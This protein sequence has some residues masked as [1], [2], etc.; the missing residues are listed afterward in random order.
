MIGKTFVFAG[1]AQF[2]VE[3]PK[4]ETLTL[5]IQKAQK[6]FVARNGKVYPPA[7][8]LRTRHNNGEWTLIGRVDEQT[9][10]ITPTKNPNLPPPDD[11]I[12]GVAKWA[13]ETAVYEKPL[14]EGYR[15]AHV[16]KC[17][18]CGMTLTDAESIARGIGPECFK[19]VP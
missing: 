7:F 15:L 1:N 18:R 11:R 6:P 3:S 8:F 12:V 5:K 13:I 14:P 2:I 10:A 4:G 17:G 19:K 9:C 16:G